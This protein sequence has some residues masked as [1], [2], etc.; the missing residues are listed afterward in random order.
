M[1]V[2]RI[3][4]AILL[5]GLLLP[6][7]RTPGDDTPAAAD[8]Q[9]YLII[10]ADDAGMCHS[11]NRATVEALE[12]GIVTSCSI[13]I[14]CPWVTEFAE[15]AKTHPQYDYGLHL[16]LNS[17]WKQ[18]RWGPVAGKSKVPSLVDEHGYLWSNVGQVAKHA[19]PEEVAIELRAQ[20]DRAKQLGI[21]VSHLDTHMGALVSRPDL[22]EVYVAVGIEHDLPVL[23]FRDL[24]EKTLKAYPTLRDVGP[25]LVARLTEQRLPLLDG[26]AQFYGG[27]THEKRLESYV[28]TIKSLPPGVS[29]LIIHCG[30][31][32]AELRAVTNSAARRD[33]DRRIFTDPEIARL[34]RD[35]GVKLINWKQ[36]RELRR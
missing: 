6:A 11:V 5:I 33:G 12:K 1:N 28:K 34:I 23:F 26:L 7:P 4:V 19:K 3:A 35:E 31:D 21:P 25:P 29:E 2:I 17:E 32:D 27:D 9:R 30:V 36:F 24:S 16:T 22:A 15:Y 13:M 8:Q 18:Y 10:H 20:I 14:P